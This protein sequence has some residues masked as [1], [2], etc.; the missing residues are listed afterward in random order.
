M[1]WKWRPSGR[2]SRQRGRGS[3][4]SGPEKECGSLR[5]QGALQRTRGA[6]TGGEGSTFL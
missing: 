4:S 2:I 3:H 5:R 1:S 6:A